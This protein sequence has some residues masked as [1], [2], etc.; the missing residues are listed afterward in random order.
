MKAY[1]EQIETGC[2]L[3]RNI[4]K[5][6]KSEPVTEYYDQLDISNGIGVGI[7]WFAIFWSPFWKYRQIGTF[8]V[9]RPHPF[10]E[11]MWIDVKLRRDKIVSVKPLNNS[12]GNVE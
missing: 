3:F 2:Y 6:L 4:W 9:K 1:I 7:G 12:V 5:V 11:K 10:K 8:K